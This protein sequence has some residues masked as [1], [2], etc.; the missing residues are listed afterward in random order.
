[1]VFISCL[2]FSGNAQENFKC[3]D[4]FGF[5]PHH[6]SCDKYW[7]C[8]NNAAELKT[9]GNGLAFDASDPKFLTENC[10]YIHNVD[11]GDRAQL[12]PAISTPHCERLYGIFADEAKCDV[13]WNCWNGEASRYQCSPGLAYD[14]EARVCM[15]ADQVPECKSE[16]GIILEVT[17]PALEEQT[18]RSHHIN[19]FIAHLQKLQEALRVPP[20]PTLPVLSPGTPTPEDCRKYYICLEGQAREY[21]C[22]IGTVFKIGDGDGT[23]NCEDPEDV[24]GCED[25]YGDL[26]LKS[27]RKSELL[28]GLQSSGSTRSHTPSAPKKPR[29]APAS[30]NAPEP[31]GGN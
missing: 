24:P 31:A 17:R 9:C 30:R 6:T 5:Y 7:K 23:G 8:D 26:D 4:D 18:D 16:V 29:P 27:I 19:R 20:T 3:P 21:G 15:W 28:A 11:C 13:F 2:L 10:D 14:R 22:P 12:E 1:M 25:Y